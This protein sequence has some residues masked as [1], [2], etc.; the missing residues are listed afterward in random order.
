[1]DICTTYNA[2][3]YQK[4]LM[5]PVLMHWRAKLLEEVTSCGYSAGISVI[6]F[7]FGLI[8]LT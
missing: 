5:Y 8:S 4:L 3:P 1:M 7:L 2:R 6:N